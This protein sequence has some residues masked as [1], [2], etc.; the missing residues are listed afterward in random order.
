M[1]NIL[2]IG[3]PHFKISNKLETDQLFEETK[4][5][6]DQN[7]I[8]F[9]DFIV[10]LGDILDTHE[11]VHVQP[12]CRSILFIKMLASYKKTFILIGNHDRINNNVFMTDEHPFTSLKKSNENIVIVDKTL[13]F[14]NF[15]FVPYVPNGRFE[16]S[17]KEGWEDKI[18]IFAHQEFK[19]CK[20]GSIISED[21]DVW[22]QDNPPVFSGHIHDYQI[23]QKNI[24]YT[25]T[26]FQHSFGDSHDKGIF[27]LKIT[28]KEHW[29]LEKIKLNI[30]RKKIIK[31]NIS[32]FEDFEPPKNCII[33]IDLEGDPI[34]IKKILEKK[35]NRDKINEYNLKIKIFH[36]KILKGNKE[37]EKSEFNFVEKLKKRIEKCEND[38]KNT[39]DEIF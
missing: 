38:V 24:C 39:F 26:P 29:N 6:L 27:L 7:N 28:D 25:G 5:Y 3:D 14:G 35:K 10:V 4:K 36:S 20:M 31:M 33:K 11:K 12:L 30:I 16:E 18:A 34:L 21:G 22:G 1:N 23:P 2:L 15:M 9:I 13:T 17:L 8:D 32:E 19:G 37:I